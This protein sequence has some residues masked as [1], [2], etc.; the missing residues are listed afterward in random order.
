MSV[1]FITALMIQGG[2][3]RCEAVPANQQG[4][5]WL[6]QANLFK[7]GVLHT[8]LL[9]TTHACRSAAAALEAITEVV[10]R[11]SAIDITSMNAA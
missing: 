6:G 5:L 9:S 3:I 1:S 4:T 2:D 10:N 11:I 7:E 8:T